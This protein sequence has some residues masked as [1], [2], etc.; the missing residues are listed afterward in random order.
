MNRII[1][2]NGASAL[3]IQDTLKGYSPDGFISCH[4]RFVQA[5]DPDFKEYIPPMAARRMSRIIKRAV[6]VSQLALQEAGVAMPDGIVFGT[7]LGC[8][9]DTEKFL[10]AV[11]DQDEQLLQPSFFIQSTHNTIASQVA[12]RLGCRAYNN[13]LVQR[14]LSFES[15]LLDGWLLFQDGEVN[16][17]LIGGHDELTPSYFTLLNKAGYYSYSED[18]GIGNFAG[19]GSACFVLGARPHESS[20][21]TLQSV[22]MWYVPNNECSFGSVVLPFL[23]R[24]G[25]S[26]DELCALFT[27]YTED[28]M[29][30][31][32]YR[33]LTFEPFAGIP[34]I[35]YK[36]YCGELF[37]ATAFGLWLAAN[38][39]RSGSLPNG[40]AC[41]FDP[42]QKPY[43][44]LHNH[45]LNRHHSV[46][47]LKNLKR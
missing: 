34:H 26:P 11:L 6:T 46:M 8:I 33:D 45:S 5:N 43:L 23:Q 47:L 16:S 29:E 21:A 13:T 32:V 12:L 15:A 27:A 36:K 3:S 41:F 2:I 9:E 42:M 17:L 38:S 20:Y 39:L 25:V 37:T 18:T 24:Q 10:H 35:P 40:N 28:D 4:Q 44:L 22:E 14:R 19:E 1:Y 30:K 31:M 7:G